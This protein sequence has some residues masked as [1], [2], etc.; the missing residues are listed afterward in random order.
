MTELSVEISIDEYLRNK[1]DY[2]KVEELKVTGKAP[3]DC[4]GLFSWFEGEKL[5]LS[6]L[7]TSK[8]TTMECFLKNCHNLKEVDLADLDTSNVTNMYGFFENCESLEKANL[9]GLN[10]SKVKDMAFFFYNCASLE[11][12]DLSSLDTKN[13]THMSAF[14]DGCKSLEE[15]NLSG[16]DISNVVG[17]NDFFNDCGSLE[18]VDLS[19]VKISEQTGIDG[20]SLFYYNRC[21]DMECITNSPEVEK[22]IDEYQEKTITV[23]ELLK[24]I[25]E[26][27]ELYNEREGKYQNCFCLKVTGQAP[28]DCGNLFY[29]YKGNYLNLSELD[30]SQTTDMYGMFWE[31]SELLAIKGIEDFDTSKV[32]TMHNMFSNCHNLTD[33]DLTNWDTSQVTDMGS[34]FHQC[35][36]LAIEQ[37]FDTSNVTNMRCM[38]EE[39]YYLQNNL[40]NFDT[41]KVKNMERM[42][43]S[44]SEGMTWPDQIDLSSFNLENCENTNCMFLGVDAEIIASD[45]KIIDAVELEQDRLEE[46]EKNIYIE[47]KND[48]EDID[49]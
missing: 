45:P 7:D 4:Y 37:N 28:K 40:Q 15:V 1:D 42:F 31:A 3:E 29:G 13:V 19:D 39:N 27:T 46:Q 43:S 9:T 25:E 10:A 48:M 32:T 41:S 16:L 49:Y 24:D 44:L 23:E 33:L 18:K 20:K 8:V 26:N 47:I 6:G 36:E 2:L 11:K 21:W 22:F 35:M 34:M 5:D 38:F 30:T 17:M 12:V 14:F